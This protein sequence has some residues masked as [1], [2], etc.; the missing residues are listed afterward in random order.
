MKKLVSL[1]LCGTLAFGLTACSQPAAPSGEPTTSP[2]PDVTPVP[3]ASPSI[4]FRAGTYTA[5]AEGRNGPLTLTMTLS[6]SGITSAE[7]TAHSETAGIADP[8]LEKLPL[9]IV[10]AQSLDVSAVSGATVT[11][12]AILAA[13][14]ECVR[15]AG[16]DPA[17]LSSTVGASYEKNLTP[18]AYQ[19][20][21]HGHHSDVTVEVQVSQSAI[22]SVAVLASGE[23]LHIGDAATGALPA[24]IVETQSVGVDVIT[25]A[26]YTSRALLGAVEDCLEQAGGREAVMAFSTPVPSQ[27]WSTE[28]KSMEVDVVVVGAG[29]TGVSAALAA[30]EGGASVVLLEKLPFYGGTSQTAGGGVLMPADDTQ[31]AKD[32]FCGYLMQKYCGFMQGDTYLDGEYPNEAAVRAL[33]ENARDTVFWLQDK[34]VPMAIRSSSF[35]K[36][37]V[38]VSSWGVDPQYPAPNAVG[39]AIDI[40]LEEFYANGGQLY[41]ETPATALLTDESG[42]VVGVRAEGK[43]GVYTFHCSAVCLCCGGYGADA[44]MIAQYAPAFKGEETVTTVGNTGDSIRLAQPIGAA[45]YD[46]G[47]LM[48]GAGQAVITDTDMIAPYKDNE[49]PFSALYVNPLGVR[50]NSEDPIPYTAAVTY[51]NPDADDYYWIICNE[52]IASQSKCYVNSYAPS[53]DTFVCYYKDYIAEGLA[54]EPDRYF[55][56]DSVAELAKQIN[57]TPTV[58]MYTLGRYNSLCEAGEDADLFKNPNYLVPMHDGPWYAI[59]ARMQFFGTVGGV[60][61]DENAAVLREDG[62]PIPGLFAAG[63]ASNHKLYNLSYTGAVSLSD[64]IVFGRI[65]GTNAAACAAQ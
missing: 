54:T 65:A 7:V 21:R 56:A 49:T 51:C 34:G 23:T 43:D 41:L 6:D 40:M 38:G 44:D 4:L 45:V 22:E 37:G 52:E 50:V 2:V 3:E 18:G 19:A 29:L 1:L 35:Q 31:Q 58:L 9:S 55:T 26:T 16:V 27:P 63:E 33:A 17:S 59:K 61:S 48:G 11:S 46:S 57:I 20:T 14:A 25:G 32:D 60:V 8:A 39:H 24:Q 10:D 36:F 15:Q 30:Q 53:D 12:E 47:L 42:A 13:A 5:T 64:N 62:S 28:E